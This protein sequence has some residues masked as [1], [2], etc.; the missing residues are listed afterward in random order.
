[1]NAWPRSWTAS[2]RK[3]NGF[4][5][6]RA[7]QDAAGLS[8]LDGDM[9]LFSHGEFSGVLAARWIGLPVLEGPHFPLSTASL[10]ILGHNPVHPESRAIVLWNALPAM[11]RI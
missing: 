9:A 7:H 11:L 4:R 3:F 1:M 2:S 5:H 8:Q 6:S 10:N